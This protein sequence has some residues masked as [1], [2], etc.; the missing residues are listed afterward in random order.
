MKLTSETPVEATRLV[1]LD[2]LK[3]QRTLCP[4]AAKAMREAGVVVFM[5]YSKALSYMESLFESEG[6]PVTKLKPA[7][8]K[9]LLLLLHGV[10]E[11]PSHCGTHAQPLSP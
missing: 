5:K 11:L 9:A 2:D 10:E 4:V 8:H 1:R 7:E 6:I 3:N